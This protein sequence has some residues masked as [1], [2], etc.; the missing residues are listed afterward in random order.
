MK[1]LQ[2]L[3]LMMLLMVALFL[4][5]CG[6]P[7]EHEEAT[8]LPTTPS[9]TK[10]VEFTQ[11]SEPTTTPGVSE[12]LKTS[13]PD[14]PVT[15]YGT[16]TVAMSIFISESTDPISLMAPW[17]VCL[18]DFLITWDE[19]GNYI[20]SVA[21]SWEISKDGNTWT[22]HIRDDIK[23]HNGDPLTAHDVK[24]SIE[25]I[26]SEESTNPWSGYL[27]RNL[28]AIEVPD[29]YTF[30][31]ITNTPEPP[32]ISAFASVLIL[33]GDYFNTVGAE[34]FEKHPIGSGPWKFVKHVP[35][36]SIVM[37]ANTGHWRQVPAYKYLREYLVP[38]EYTRV[39]A[40]ESGEAD[41]AFLLSADRT[42]AMMNEGWRVEKIGLPFIITLTFP[43][44]WMTD[45][46]T[47]DVRVRQALSY[48]I[49]RQELCDTLW[50]GLAKSGCRWFMHEGCWGWDPNWKPD[51][52]D[53]ELARQ[54][55]SQAG[56]P[57]AFNNPTIRYFITS[58]DSNLA[59]AL[60]NYWARVGIDVKV[61]V[62]DYM[63][64]TGM[65]FV[66]QTD[67]NSPAVGGIIPFGYTSVFDST[68]GCANMYTSM[69]VHTAANDP[70]ADRLYHEAVMTINDAERKQLWTEFQDYAKEMWVN[71]G[72]ATIEPYLLVGPNLGEFT[73][74]TYLSMEAAYA[75]IQHP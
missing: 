73:T 18:F 9:I 49:N 53:P 19:K 46:P 34:E 27:R 32:L 48:A 40:L 13:A 45:G 12:A 4:S 22:F 70:V 24:F 5:N 42:V 31:Y 28:F 44:T 57:D 61:E 58:R 30:V 65:F 54:L 56:Y 52:Y 68:Y 75:G 33:P 47:S 69:G 67:P 20:G 72:I 38:E 10:P 64:W 39:A 63:V 21:K 43:G 29:D 2:I 74:N 41:M 51:P 62:I 16:I 59:T 26:I 23:F 25:R 3:S 14:K 17:G 55:L 1:R 60:Q 6:K 50:K 7:V 35:A 11:P 8:L 37:E 66:R 15:P 71:V 36:T